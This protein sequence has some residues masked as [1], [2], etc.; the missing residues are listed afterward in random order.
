MKFFALM[1]VAVAQDT[2]T[3]DSD[4]LADEI[5]ATMS[6]ISSDVDHADYNADDDAAL[7]ASLPANGCANSN[8]C[9]A[10]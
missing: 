7:Q 6:W 3:L 2:C 1:A 9:V 10:L 4:C 8:D 5:C